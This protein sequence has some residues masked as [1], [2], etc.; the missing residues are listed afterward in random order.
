MDRTIVVERPIPA[1]PSD[2]Y[3]AFLEVQQL[4]R[5]WWPHLPDATYRVDP[6]VG[7][8]YEIRSEAVGIGVM[9]EYQ[10][11]IPDR[12]ILMT[13]Q[14]LDEGV[15]QGTEVVA[16]DL[17]ADGDHGTVVTVTH[18]LADAARDGD[19]IRRGWE[20]VLDRLARVFPG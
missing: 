10:E 20:D 18:E 13:W 11:L 17:A 12:R 1:S 16:I 3:R 6:R 19:D 9:G 15:P 4:R 2:A 8:T 7:G 14:W 5:W